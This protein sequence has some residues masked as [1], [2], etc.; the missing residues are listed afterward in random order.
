M[1][2]SYLLTPFITWFVTGVTKFLVNSVKEKSLA[3]KLIGYGGFP[4][5]HSAI[6][7]SMAALIGFKLGIDTA[8][9]GVAITLAYIVL[10][11]ASSLRQKV[12][13]HAQA[14]NALAERTNEKPLRER[15]GHTRVE[16]AGGIAVGILCAYLIS[17]WPLIS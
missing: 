7:C 4:S 12:G 6:V 16:I 14:I 3:F 1:D 5:N 2:L 9:F 8:A 11:D 10:L 15:M 13:Q 17:L